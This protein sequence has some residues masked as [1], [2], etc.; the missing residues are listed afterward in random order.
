MPNL[1]SSSRLPNGTVVETVTQ[2]LG[3]DRSVNKRCFSVRLSNKQ[4]DIHG[5]NARMLVISQQ[6]WILPYHML[7]FFL[8]GYLSILKLSLVTDSITASLADFGLSLYPSCGILVR[9]PTFPTGQSS[10]TLSPQSSVHFT[11]LSVENMIRGTGIHVAI[12]SMNNNIV[13]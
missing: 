13:R 10:K 11:R 6:Y 3:R 9:K 4:F 12:L 8:T 2:I 1:S 5:Q 7:F